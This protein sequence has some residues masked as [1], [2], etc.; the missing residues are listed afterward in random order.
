[1]ET[2]PLKCTYLEWLQ[3]NHKYRHT[4][5][6]SMLRNEFGEGPHMN[7]F[8]YPITIMDSDGEK[9]HSQIFQATPLEEPSA[10]FLTALRTRSDDFKTRLILIDA[11]SPPVMNWRYIDAIAAYH[12]LDPCFLDSIAMRED[13]TP[14]I[15]MSKEESESQEKIHDQLV[16][17]YPILPSETSFLRMDFP[18]TFLHATILTTGER[19]TG[20]CLSI[21][22]QKAQNSTIT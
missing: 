9:L 4:Q 11:M 15:T 7:P 12:R 3:E 17:E 18:W 19:A 8:P 6:K 5:L 21:P 2:E 13:F 1:M 14:F 22:Y 10:S 16:R 20:K